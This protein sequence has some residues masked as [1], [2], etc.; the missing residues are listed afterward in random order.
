MIFHS[1][2]N[3]T[4]FHK[5]GWAPNLVLIQRSRG[6]SEMAYYDKKSSHKCC[7]A[8][9]CNKRS[10]NRKDLT[11]H[12]FWNVNVEPRST[13]TFT[14]NTLYIACTVIYSRKI[15][16]RTHIKITQ[17]W[18]STFKPCFHAC[19]ISVYRV[20]SLTWPASMQIYWN[21]RRRLHKKRVRLPQ[22]WFG[23]PTWRPFHC[24]GTPIWPPWRHV[25][26]LYHG[27]KLWF[28]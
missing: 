15:Y 26:T 3:K 23:T 4:H 24:S 12:Y 19:V 11:F 10:D 20:F 22:D 21:K 5:K 7:T 27:I 28:G 9:L 25:K 14:H 18:K 6:N 13:F 8:E 2:A 16:V 1:H 17:Q